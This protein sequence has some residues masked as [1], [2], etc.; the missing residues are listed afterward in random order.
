MET[1]TNK[2]ELMVYF[3]EMATMRRIEITSDALYKQQLI[4]GFCHL[5][6]GQEAIAM[7]MEAGLTQ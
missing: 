1:K 3:K 6:D 2:E 7:G 5:A 4:R